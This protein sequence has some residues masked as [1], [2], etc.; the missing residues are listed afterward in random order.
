MV[1]PLRNKAYTCIY[2]VEH[3]IIVLMIRH[4]SHDNCVESIYIFT[5]SLTTPSSKTTATPGVGTNVSILEI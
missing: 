1:V 3:A 4:P 5:D 2:V